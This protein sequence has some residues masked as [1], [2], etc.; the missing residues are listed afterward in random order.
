MHPKTSL[1]FTT[2]LGTIA[3]LNGVE[4]TTRTFAV[5]PVIEQKLEEKLKE[6][7]E[8]LGQIS[9]QNVTQQSGQ[10]LGIESSRPIAGRKDTSGGQRR[11]PTDPTDNGES[12]TYNCLQTN[13]D[14]SRRYDKLDAWRHKPDFE[15]LVAMAILKQ[16]GRDMIMAG[17][18]GVERA[19]TTDIDANPM[20][21]D[22]AEGWLFKIRDTAPTQVMSDGGLTVKT[23]GTNNAALKAIYVKAGVELFDGAAAHNAVGGSAH[24]VADYSS[25]DALVLDAKRLLPEWHRNRTDLVVI[26]GADLVDDKIFSIAQ[27]TGTQATEIEATDRI[28][29]STKTL[30]GLPA[31]QVP[32]FPSD[33]VLIT[34]LKN[35][36]IYMQEG[37]RRRRLTDE[38]EYDRI[39]NYESVNMDYV[40]ED[41]ELVVLVENI[42]IGGSPARIA[43]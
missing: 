29:R 22:L 20:L 18:N 13:F 1:L 3:Q 36:A 8:F 26:V 21:E 37:T 6:S 7:I 12:N 31:V 17:F 28:L 16:Q 27:T 30:G 9:I 4:S 34:T 2:Y 33:A 38:P 35:L 43:P 42:V 41:Y 24:A 39:A 15:R 5:A 14:W 40:V 32:F 19:T 25:L 23:D 11:N 10:T